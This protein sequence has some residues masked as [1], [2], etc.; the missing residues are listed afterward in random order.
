MSAA[1]ED[2]RLTGACCLAVLLSVAMS[3][4]GATQG[5]GGGGNSSDSGGGNAPMVLELSRLEVLC[6]AFHCDKDQKKQITTILDDAHKSAAPVREQLVKTRA[7]IA[8]AIEAHKSQADV[9][10]AVKNYAVQVDAMTGVE[11]KAL[12]HVL[13]AVNPDQRTSAAAQTAFFLMR[14]IFLDNKKWN[15][16]PDGFYGY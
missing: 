13:L 11:M 8:A 3:T 9:D 10:Q 14:G 1:F 5:K 12:A 7:A 2:R 4:V 15:V 6:Q 16:I